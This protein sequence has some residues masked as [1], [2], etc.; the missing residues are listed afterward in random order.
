MLQAGLHVAPCDLRRAAADATL[1][2]GAPKLRVS[3]HV[4]LLKVTSDKPLLPIRE[5]YD[6]EIATLLKRRFVG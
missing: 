5:D 2:D 6:R 3:K 1:G 4:A